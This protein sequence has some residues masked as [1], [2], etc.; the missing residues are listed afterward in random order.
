MMKMPW[1]VYG[2]VTYAALAT[3][4]VTQAGAQTTAW[5]EGRF[6]VDT[7]GVV[8]RSAIVLGR[9]N[10]DPSEAMPLG[11]GRLGVAVWSADGLTAQLNRD[12]TLPD[13]LAAGQVAIPGLKA[14]TEAK[15]YAGRLDLYRGEFQEQGGG[16]RVTAWVEADSDTLIVDVT[17]ADPNTVQ[18]AQ[19]KLWT[20]RTP[21]AEFHGRIGLLAQSWVDDKHPEASGRSFGSLAAITAD[22]RGVRAEVTDPLTI[23]VRFTPYPDGHFRVLSA[24]P[25]YEGKGDVDSMASRAL[26]EPP[27]A[28]H[29][30]RWEA[31]WKRAGLIKITSKDG[32]GEYMENLRAI[33]LYVAA[34]ERGEEYPGTQAGVADMISAA[35]DEHKWDSSAFWHWNLRMQVAANIGAGLWDLNAPYFNLYREN[36]SSMEEWT[37]K[38]MGGRAGACVPETMR[39]NGRGIEYESS[40][41]PISI[42]LDCAEDFK[43]YYNAR[44]LSTGAEVALWVWEQYLVTGDREFLERN[45]PVMAAS[46]RFLLAYQRPGADG[47]LHTGPSNAHETQWDVTDPTTDLAAMKAL[48]PATIEAATLLGKDAELVRQ[49]RTAMGRIPAFPRMRQDGPQT[50]LA[51]QDGAGKDV[52]AESYEPGAEIHN[53]ENIGLEPVWPYGLIGDTSPLF[54]LARRTYARRPNKGGIDWSFDPIQAARLGLG[55]EAGT[56]LV[57]ITEKVQNFPNG[58]AKW[59]PTAREFYVE[60][61]GVVADA[62]QEALAQD[63]DGV[64]RVAPAL[65]PGWDFAGSVF[66]HGKSKVDVETRDGVVTTVVIEAGTT[67]MVQMR[68]PWPG[69][70]VDVIAGKAGTRVARGVPGP[71]IGF[72]AIAGRSYLI[73][74]QSGST[75]PRAFAPVSGTPAPMAKRLGPV[76]IGLFATPR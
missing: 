46:A 64:I 16:M 75:R 69:Q 25:R 71:E 53:V 27:E 8:G 35:R 59:E 49:L 14:L 23:T 18:T 11:N 56:S 5:H 52:I 36:L 20:P 57:E 58:M 21:H 9:A 10:T 41:E 47:L 60:E 55:K 43:P 3:M 51:E 63:Y 67:G 15:D 22:G 74:R 31:F 61:A 7:A 44:T 50:V 1:Q 72:R 68:N 17:G 34:V 32:A 73:E 4:G 48:Y 40:W 65:P 29:S 26:L 2:I 66:V 33:Y 12:D 70:A 19:L 54:E 24:A 13:R 37:R 45:Y 42:G 6:H 62:L 30:A 38:H 28:L 39:F 76:Q